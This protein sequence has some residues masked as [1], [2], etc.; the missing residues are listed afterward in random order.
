MKK[1]KTIGIVGYGH[2]GK[3][4][5]TLIHKYFSDIE[6]KKPIKSDFINK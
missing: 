6:V 4:L 5:K 3:F 2:F 1:I